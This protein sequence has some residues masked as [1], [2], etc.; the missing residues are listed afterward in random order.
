MSIR[1]PPRQSTDGLQ[2]RK[3]KEQ[4]FYDANRPVGATGAMGPP[5]PQGPA[6]PTGAIGPQGPQGIAG[7]TTV[8]VGTTTT[9]SHQTPAGV[10]NGGDSTNVVLNFTIPQGP[11][12]PTTAYIFDGGDP[13]SVY[14]VGPAFDCGGVS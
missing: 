9:V 2:D 11:P 8:N 7:P 10:S 4:A 14:S 5:G 12:G 13:Y 3:W 1:R 6:G